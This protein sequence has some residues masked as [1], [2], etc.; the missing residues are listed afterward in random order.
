[1]SKAGKIFFDLFIFIFPIAILLSI[2]TQTTWTIKIGD[3]TT[4]NCSGFPFLS[5]GSFYECIPANTGDT[6]VNI[7]NYII[8]ALCKLTIAFLLYFLFLRK[9]PLTVFAKST[10]ITL[11]VIINILGTAYLYAQLARVCNA[12]QVA[13]HL[14]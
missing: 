7:S 9:F 11:A 8:N 14:G 2:I 6:W 4:D 1:M 5:I 12:C 10:F 3:C 13:C